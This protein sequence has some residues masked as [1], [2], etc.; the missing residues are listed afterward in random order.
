LF[1]KKLLSLIFVSLLFSGNAYA[2]TLKEDN[3]GISKEWLKDKTVNELLRN[4]FGL[5]QGNGSEITTTEDSVQYHLGTYIDG[6][7][8]MVICFV[9]VKKTICKLP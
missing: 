2:A 7:F 5:Y 4:G 9:D 6:K 8:Q 3:K 1:I